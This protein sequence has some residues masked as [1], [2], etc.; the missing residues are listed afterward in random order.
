MKK[1]RLNTLLIPAVKSLIEYLAKR[2]GKSAGQIIEEGVLFLV[3]QLSTT[4][5]GFGSQEVEEAKS[6]FVAVREARKTLPDGW[7]AV[8]VV[9][10]SEEEQGYLQNILYFPIGWCTIPEEKGSVSYRLF[11]VPK[12]D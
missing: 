10:T 1:A 6:T 12:L 8:A 7:N 11:A 3:R 4:Y 2:H 5:G 9:H